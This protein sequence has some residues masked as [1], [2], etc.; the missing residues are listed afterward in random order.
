[1]GGT[2]TPLTRTPHPHPGPGEMGTELCLLPGRRGLGQG[3]LFR[4]WKRSGL[5]FGMLPISDS[6]EG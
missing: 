4:G 5:C 3:P 6:A 1:M 2:E